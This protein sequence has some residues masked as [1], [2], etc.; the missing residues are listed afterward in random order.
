MFFLLPLLKECVVCLVPELL[1]SS[2]RAREMARLAQQL[3]PPIT[4]LL[5]GQ[6]R[7]L[8]WYFRS[9]NIKQ[10]MTGLMARCR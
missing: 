8:R 6:F 2:S 9:I 4:L 7:Y 5:L 10:S 1:L 3:C